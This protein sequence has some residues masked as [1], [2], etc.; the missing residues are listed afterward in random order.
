VTIAASSFDCGVETRAQND[1]RPSRALAGL[2]GYTNPYPSSA[3]SKC[4]YEKKALI[5]RELEGAGY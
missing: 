5:E 4:F 3:F 2:V 1:G